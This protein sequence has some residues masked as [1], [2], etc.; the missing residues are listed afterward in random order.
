MRCTVCNENINKSVLKTRRI[1]QACYQYERKG[2]IIHVP[3]PK[4]VI[5]FDE[6]NNPICHICGQAHKKLGGHIYWHHKMTVEE[7]KFRYKLNATDKLTNPEY[8]DTMRQHVFNN[9]K[10]IRQ[11]LIEAGQNTRYQP[12]DPRC[13]GRINKRRK[14]PVVSFASADTLK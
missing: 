9:P 4:G 12:N 3:S 1:C 7:Y 10:I 5:T 11:N 6:N 13:T 8:R 14:T 2:G